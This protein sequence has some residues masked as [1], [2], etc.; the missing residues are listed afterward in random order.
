MSVVN[1]QEIATS[2]SAPRNDE[3]KAIEKYGKNW[4]T[5]DPSGQEGYS[6][7]LGRVG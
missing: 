6:V 7:R 3:E 4:N 5:N 2:L 1:S